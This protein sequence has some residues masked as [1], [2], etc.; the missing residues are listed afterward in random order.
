MATIHS[1]TGN[2]LQ[3][4]LKEELGE[5]SARRGA[6]ES[7]NVKLRESPERMAGVLRGMLGGQLG[8]EA[9]KSW[10]ES[11]EAVLIETNTGSQIGFGA[12][13]NDKSAD[14]NARNEWTWGKVFEDERHRTA[15]HNYH[16]AEAEVRRLEQQ[17]AVSGALGAVALGEAEIDAAMWEAGLASAREDVVA[18]KRIRALTTLLIATELNLPPAEA[19]ASVVPEQ[20]VTEPSIDAVPLAA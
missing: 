18:T 12:D 14:S 17:Q 4:V 7:Y 13:P 3:A 5:R 6:F 8:S 2:E 11:V 9:D 10:A 15:R 19:M 20:L 1:R 16:A